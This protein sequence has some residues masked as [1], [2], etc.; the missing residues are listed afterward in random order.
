MIGRDLIYVIPEWSGGFPYFFQFKSEFCNKEFMI[1][2]TVSPRFRF[3]WLYT[4][5]PCLAAKNIISLI[6][7]LSIYWCPCVESSVVL[8]EEGVCYD[9]LFSCKTLLAFALL[10][11]VLQGQICLLLQISLD[12]LLLHSRAIFW[13]G[14]LFFGVSSRRSCRS[15]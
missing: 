13:K 12:F 7:V 6:L 3:C 15:S 14:H 1:W 5:S 11:F 9:P 10:H 4:T 8:F 2:S